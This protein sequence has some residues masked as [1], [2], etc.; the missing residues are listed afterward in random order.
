MAFI[1]FGQLIF[2]IDNMI[3]QTIDTATIFTHTTFLIHLQMHT[4]INQYA[5]YNT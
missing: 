5:T 2:T 4:T 3:A 1:A